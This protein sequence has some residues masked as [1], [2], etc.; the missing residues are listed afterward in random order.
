M[1]DQS[2]ARLNV[3]NLKTLENKGAQKGSVA[4]LVEIKSKQDSQARLSSID[5]GDKRPGNEMAIKDMFE[6]KSKFEESSVL[7]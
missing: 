4:S 3:S 5:K 1:G 7:D 6:A 2:N